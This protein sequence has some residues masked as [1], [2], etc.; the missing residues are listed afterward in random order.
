M[1]LQQE[2]DRMINLPT[3]RSA[4]RAYMQRMLGQLKKGIPLSY[5]ERRNLEAYITRY[6]TYRP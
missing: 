2:I 6:T 5:Q 4:D 1:D 3:V